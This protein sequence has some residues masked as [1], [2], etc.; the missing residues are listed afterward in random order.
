[1]PLS[2]GRFG[3]TPALAL[4]YDSGTGN[5]PYGFGWKIDYP[6]ITRRTDQGL[7]QY[8]DDRESDVFL[9]SGAEDLVPVI[10]SDGTRDEHERDGYRV[11]RYRPR[12]EG[13]FARIER[14]T[15][16]TDRLNVFWRSISRDNVTTFYGKSAGSRIM[17]PADP[18]KIFAWLLCESLDDKGNAALYEYIAEDSRNVNR[19]LA[20]ESNR[21]DGGRTANRYLKRVKYGN[22][23][24]PN[25]QPDLSLME[26]LFELV[27]D[28]GDHSGNA[29]GIAP[30]HDW[31][32]R[33][34]PFSSSRAGFE[35]RTYRRCQRIL[36]FHRFAELGANPRLVRT[37]ELDYDDFPYAPGFD[38][39]GE[40]AWQGSTRAG[41]LLRRATPFGYAD[42]GSRKSMPPVELMYARPQVVED[43]QTL[44][45][46]S[47][48]NLPAGIDDR[49]AQWLDL[50][51]EG[52]SGMLSE[53]DG[54]WWYK[55][56]LGN[57]RLG[58]LQRVG[59]R[60]SIAR[61]GQ[62]HFLDL[63]GDGSLDVVA[64]DHP[65]A[66][67]HKRDD[68]GQW[69]PFK[70]FASQ[71]N[72]AWSDPNLRFIDLT[73]D[74]RAD[75]LITHDDQLLWHPSLGESGFGS[76]IAS[77]TA[78]DE[79]RGP[80]VVF[81][82]GTETIFLADMSGDGLPD[83]VRVRRSQ[84]CYWP[85]L[86]YGHFGPRVTMDDAPVL[87]S[88]EHFDPRRVR[89]ADIDGSG[90]VDLIY[91]GSDAVRMYFNRSGNGWTAPY[92]L[93]AF[94][95]FDNTVNVQVTD[96]LG[97]GTACLVWSSPLPHDAPAPLRFVDLMDG[98][99]PHLLVGVENN[100]GARTVV[101]Y[102]ASTQFYLQDQQAGRPWI[103]RLPFPVHVVERVEL[104]DDISRNRFVTRYA[105]HHGFFDGVEREFR[106]FG[107]VEQIDTEELGALTADQQLPPATNIDQSSH[108]PPM[109][110]RTWFHTGVFLG[111][112]RISRYFAGLLDATDQGEYYR[113]PG[114]TDA[115]AAPLL[116]D[117]TVLPVGLTAD[118]T[119]EAC[120]ALKGMMLR[121]EVY[122]LDGTDKQPH[123][124]AVTEQ[125]FTLRMLQ[126]KGGNRHPVF[127]SHPRES[128]LYHYERIPNDPRVAHSLTIECD[129]FGNTLK[130][131]T[132]AYGRRTPDPNLAAADQAKQAD[133]HIIYTDNRFTNSI[134][135]PDD[136]RVPLPS[137]TKTYELTGL[138]L[139]AGA[140]RFTLDQLATAG[141]TAAELAYE[142]TPT[143]NTLQKRLTEHVR[144]LYRRNDFTAAL[145]LGQVESLALAYEVYRLAL[146]PGLVSSVYGTRITDA[147][148][149]GDGG[150][151]HSES[152]AQWWIPSGRVLFS[153]VDGSAAAELSN[154][155]QHFFLPRRFRD[156]FGQT[157]L[158]TYDRYDLMLAETRD[159]LDNRIT[160]GERDSAGNL[161][162][163]GHDYRVLKPRVI[164]DP[165]ANRS[166]ASF[167][168]LGMVVGVAVMGKADESPRRGDLLDSFVP[169]LPDDVIA[170]HLADPLADPLAVLGHATTRMI[171]DLS[172]YYR[173]KHAAQPAP[174][175][176]YTL[177]RETHDAD[178]AAGQQPRIQHLFAYS[179]G[180]GREI[181]SKAQAELGLVPVR[182]ANGRIV[183]VNG[184]P[185]MT[186]TGVSPRWVGSGWT[187]FNNKGKPV[188][189]F[190]PFFTDRHSFEFDV[191][192]GVSPISCYDPIG[193]MAARVHA[194]HAWEKVIIG[195]WQNASW[196]VNDTVLIADPK[197]DPD[198]G[199]LLGRLNDSDCLPTW[200]AQ[201]QAGGLGPDEQDAAVKA[202]AHAAT[203]SLAYLDSLGRTFLTIAHNR[204]EPSGAPPSDPPVEE[205]Y[206]TRVALDIEGNVR[207][208][209]DAAGRAAV[210]YD[211]NILGGRIHQASM[212]AGERW[213]L[214]DVLGKPVH[215]YDGRGHHVRTEY[216][217]L[218]RPLRTFVLGADPQRP[219]TE[220]L[221]AK[222]D[223]GEG[224][225]NDVRFNLRTRPYK[226][227]DGAG[228]VTND[229]F[230][231]KGN[232]LQTDRQLVTDYKAIPDWS[233]APALQTETFLTST[234]YDAVDRPV[235]MTT[236]DASVYLPTYNEANLLERVDVRLRGVQNATRF[237]ANIDYDAKGQRMRLDYGN[238]IR[239]DYTYDRLTFRLTELLTTRSTDQ[240]RL[241]DLSY[242]YDA[243][244]NI[245][246]IHDAAQQTI[247]FNNQVVT[248]VSSYVYDAVYRLVHTDAREHIGQTLP[249]QTS[250][251]DQSRVNLPHPSDGQAMRRYGED[252]RYDAVG[253]LL[254][255]IHQATNGNWTRSY[256][257]QEISQLEPGV[258]SN[259]LSRT[260]VG[261]DVPDVY[262]HDFHGSMT[263]MPHLTVMEWDYR[264]CLSATSRQ[265]GGTP[266]KTFYVYASTGQRVRKVTERQNGTRKSERIYL[267]GYEVYRAYDASGTTATLQR[268]TL[269]VMDDRRR[270]ALVETRVVGTEPG[271]P[272][273]LIR[274]Q[275]DNHL[276]S[277]TLE[278]DDQAQ[279]I[280]YEEYYPHGSTSYQ[281]G[282]SVAEVSLKRYRYT[283]KERDEETGFF[284]HGARYYAPWLGRWISADP[285]GVNSDGPNLYAYGRNNP[286]TYVDPT[287]LE[288][289]K[290]EKGQFQWAKTKEENDR[291]HSRLMGLFEAI[292]I[293]GWGA[294][295]IEDVLKKHG[296]DVILKHYGFESASRFGITNRDDAREENQR[297]ALRAILAYHLEYTGDT[298]SAYRADTPQDQ[299]ERAA[300]TA[301]QERIASWTRTT[302]ADA[303][304]SIVGAGAAGIANLLTDDP[305]KIDASRQFGSNLGNVGLTLSPA[306][307]AKIAS[308]RA[309]R[310][311]DAASGSE[312]PPKRY[313]YKTDLSHLDKETGARRLEIDQREQMIDSILANE[314]K[315]VSLTFRPR[316]NPDLEYMGI[317]RKGVGTQL[318]PEAFRSRF[319]LSKTMLHEEVHHLWWARGITG[320]RDDHHPPGSLLA[321]EFYG[322]LNQWLKSLGIKP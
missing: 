313:H 194:N 316:Y 152:D 252:Y 181:Q 126:A 241:Q 229:A 236:P 220:L 116:L 21:G 219:T 230:D 187:V 173:T 200:Y 160:V 115:Q 41:S 72:I 260:V 312:K 166:A 259:R 119:R 33:P 240:A 2:P 85:N 306:I 96:L 145:P 76:R 232:T 26:W 184:V 108:V 214:D 114:L 270:I 211:Y 133:V 258:I 146:T 262:T 143:A 105:Y 274:Y 305:I 266:E 268:D 17:D 23:L 11:T 174:T 129:D 202:A 71:P 177:T 86:G 288:G 94:P 107:M 153:P 279:V 284:Y 228:I 212:E 196:D 101:K 188:R 287:G 216:D 297:A 201:R 203:P 206:A 37:L 112:D 281:A 300:A 192:I 45:E 223:Y 176:V 150:Y 169:D 275:F 195:A 197:V 244:G 148:L 127:Y 265:A 269:H 132:V 135:A 125:N 18:T 147:M 38:V 250:W 39:R 140:N 122:A 277:A 56:N 106:G 100:F 170:A 318:G 204:F 3:F 242:T 63:D 171:Y 50:N 245:T 193:R 141:A 149:T 67:F 282:R 311:V 99:K 46:G 231:F 191:R 27:M 36:M 234:A 172:A 91:L 207:Q 310:P 238:N 182:D 256:T 246:R 217:A 185:Q 168:A 249:T 255:L 248:P 247:Y 164:T 319:E 118:E 251:N 263:T 154:A 98:Q 84:I 78:A 74:G 276:G 5:G 49:E 215:A 12:I 222:T 289:D 271:V 155:Q 128:I 121:Q 180:F 79:A 77:R 163:P 257:Y 93:R 40:L 151:V 273:Q 83:L 307:A 178:L 218:R 295:T 87:A 320:I 167:D 68:R 226:Q 20:S 278:L 294:K 28:Y 175:V 4:D 44:A 213:A 243:V 24:S 134:Q 109:L 70:L 124:Y 165:N 131:A 308:V 10:N 283:G 254:Q 92:V 8:L 7:P 1:L 80:R 264:D 29:P 35:V 139:S 65:C 209:S 179:D 15:N 291:R 47:Y 190:E 304:T 199:G 315:G 89:L 159:A 224:Q 161:V 53:H 117:D 198:V 9:I 14:W 22:R 62:T 57:G 73:G 317:S 59:Q 55:P 81:A 225:A 267:G 104:Y 303:H 208:V 162:S 156:P 66:G 95:R 302:E 322:T 221:I 261:T 138:A 142:Q 69:S 43:V 239:T 113:E 42:N 309:N 158:V 183:V 189:Q 299:K 292:K 237:V 82:D 280:S 110:T 137:E 58:P 144:T 111:A 293:K 301:E 64:L 210:R 296:D 34:D 51:G 227:Y 130:A 286:I 205:H 61:R 52:L 157:T 48:A 25:L 103:T 235:S 75:V 272:Q 6:S 321:R 186:T 102:T 120:R 298:T 253:N 136:Y 97:N 290:P 32:I 285:S 123:P 90:T 88:Q 314:L 19:G 31:P 54:A 60:P 233:T 16:L 13:M 30:D